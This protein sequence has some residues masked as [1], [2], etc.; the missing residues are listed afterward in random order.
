MIGNLA[1]L[2]Q[3]NVKRMLAYSSVSQA[4][5]MLIAIAANNELGGTGAAL[6]PD[7]V[8]AR[9]RSARSPSSPRASGS[10]AET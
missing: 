3:R 8:R 9:S 7:P 5:F 6:L 2:A 10:C 4:G 1:A